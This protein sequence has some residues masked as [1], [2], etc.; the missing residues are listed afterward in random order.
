[1]RDA[2]VVVGSVNMCASYAASKSSTG[3]CMFAGTQCFTSD[4]FSDAYAA[5]E[6]TDDCAAADAMQCYNF[7]TT[8]GAA[9]RALLADARRSAHLDDV[10]ES[11]FFGML[12]VYMYVC[13][14]S[15]ICSLWYVCMTACQF[16]FFLKEKTVR[17]SSLPDDDDLTAW[18]L[19]CFCVCAGR[20]CIW[21]MEQGFFDEHNAYR[22]EVGMGAL[23]WNDDLAK[24]D[25]Y[26]PTHMHACMYS[27][28]CLYKCA[29]GCIYMHF[30][31]MYAY[32]VHMYEYVYIYIYI[33]I[34]I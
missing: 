7:D 9:R 1:M 5:A 18:V 22:A 28:T 23:A 25:E 24:V 34:Y 31:C 20:V 13:V 15:C 30:C 2:S 29:Y 11:C 32:N 27:Y 21:Q 19:T 17:A 8:A 26:S 14:C 12:C 16:A 33:Y 10:R 6:Q 4:D 3:F